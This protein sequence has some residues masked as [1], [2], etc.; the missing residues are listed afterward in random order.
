MIRHLL[1][2]VAPHLKPTNATLKT[3]TG[4]QIKPLGAIS[5]QVEATEQKNNWNC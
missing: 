1:N 2:F 3:Y 4:E 5:V